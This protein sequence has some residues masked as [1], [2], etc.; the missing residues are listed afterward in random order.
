M[1]EIEINEEA[2]III[3]DLY[4]ETCEDCFISC[5]KCDILERVMD[6][7]DERLQEIKG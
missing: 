1:N 6:R 4:V 5:I 7:L 2:Y 3:E